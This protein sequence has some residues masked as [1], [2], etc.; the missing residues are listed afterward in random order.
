MPAYGHAT[1]TRW[2]ACEPSLYSTSWSVGFAVY[3]LGREREG[4]IDGGSRTVQDGSDPAEVLVALG[5]LVL[6]WRDT[7]LLRDEARIIAIGAAYP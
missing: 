4:P 7:E 6:E 1:V 2:V 3:K 5:E